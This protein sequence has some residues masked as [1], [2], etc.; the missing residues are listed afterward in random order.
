MLRCQ[1]EVGF[2]IH[3][4]LPLYRMSDCH[5]ALGRPVHSKR[6]M[7]LDL[8]EDAVSSKGPPDLSATGTYGQ[9]V[10][11]YGMSHDQV[12]DYA[13]QA[14]REYERD[15]TNGL[16]PEWILQNFDQAW[17]TETP[18]LHE[19]GAYF[20]T[21]EYCTSCLEQLGDGKDGKALEWLAEY[22]VACMPGCRTYRRR[23]TPSRPLQPAEHDVD[24]RDVDHAS[25][26]AGF[27][28]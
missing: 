8:C 13:A 14:W 12:M 24:H 6:Y 5:L 16:F 1:N 21:P 20:T 23:H 4:G 7:M 19:L 9:L 25:L 18:S 2:R 22:L 11:S 28:S 27:R 3:K 15:P 26:V 10:G 17:K